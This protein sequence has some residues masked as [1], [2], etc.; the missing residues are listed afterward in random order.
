M[1]KLKQT[2][3]QSQLRE[4]AGWTLSGDAITRTFALKDFVEAMEFVNQVAQLAEEA[5][6]HPDIDIRWNKVTLSLS[7]HSDSGL[8]KKDFDLARRVDRAH[9][10]M[11][12]SD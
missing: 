1:S 3:I 8:T 9:A 7:T 6:H 11:R 12:T 2:E 10:E 4:T 5:W